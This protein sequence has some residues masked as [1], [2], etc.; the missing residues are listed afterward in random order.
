MTK[1]TRSP[2]P[3]TSNKE[4]VRTIEPSALAHVQGGTYPATEYEAVPSPDPQR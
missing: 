4:M 1:R 2:R 3:F